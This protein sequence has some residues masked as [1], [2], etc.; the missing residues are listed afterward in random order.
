MALSRL[1][2]RCAVART[3]VP[4]FSDMPVRPFAPSFPAFAANGVAPSL[5][6]ITRTAQ[7]KFSHPHLPVSQSVPSPVPSFPCVLLGVLSVLFL[8]LVPIQ[9]LVFNTRPSSLSSLWRSSPAEFSP[10]HPLCLFSLFPHLAHSFP[11][12]WPGPL[13][14]ASCSSFRF[15]LSSSLGFLVSLFFLFPFP[16]QHITTTPYRHPAHRTRRRPSTSSFLDP[17]PFALSSLISI[18][19]SFRV[20]R[21]RFAPYF[22]FVIRFTF[23]SFFLTFLDSHS[24]LHTIALAIFFFARCPSVGP[25]FFAGSF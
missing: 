21:S 6:L 8:A 13:P 5:P 15:S 16:L 9:F 18:L 25:R 1:S 3:V 7:L 10:P 20:F 12:S 22:H 24:D 17:R 23:A 19:I 2:G 4:S 11:L 14:P